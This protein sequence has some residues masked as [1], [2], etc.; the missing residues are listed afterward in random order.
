MQVAVS[1]D[2]VV[3]EFQLVPT[4][5]FTA[6]SQALLSERIARRM[7]PNKIYC[8]QLHI[9]LGDDASACVFYK[10]FAE[11]KRDAYNLRIEMNPAHYVKLQHLLTP[12]WA[13]AVEVYFINGDVAFDV[14]VPINNVFML[15]NHARR[16]M[17]LY[18]ETKYF[19]LPHQRKLNAFCR[20]YDKTK[21]LATRGVHVEHDLTRVEIVFKPSIKI[22]LTNIAT[23]PPEFNKYYYAAVLNNKEA[24]TAKE[25]ERV[26]QLQ[27][28][29][30][31]FTPHIRKQ[32][33]KAL[34]SQFELDFNQLASEHWADIL[35]KYKLVG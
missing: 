3:I 21:Q 4:M 27:I 2:K 33:K 16:K 20:I 17:R 11:K 15:A 22:P 24:L 5:V 29:A 7:E 34:A 9:K 1:V 26:A 6:W 19:G 18:E 30:N 25:Q 31:M 35:N 28:G 14:P 8:Y 23:H 10:N 12:L 13:E 32:T